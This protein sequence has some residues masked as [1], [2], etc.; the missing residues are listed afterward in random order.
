[1][2]PTN[3]NRLWKF[4]QVGWTQISATTSNKLI[5]RMPNVCAAVLKEDIL[6]S[7]KSTKKHKI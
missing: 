1:M 5:E 7:R 2:R 6:K 3:Q 4:L